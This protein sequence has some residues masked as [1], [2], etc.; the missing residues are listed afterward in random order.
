MIKVKSARLYGGRGVITGCKCL[1]I[2]TLEVD[3]SY[4]VSWREPTS[5]VPGVWS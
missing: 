1:E 2:Y 4:G 3:I 5:L